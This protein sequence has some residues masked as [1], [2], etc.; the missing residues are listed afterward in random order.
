MN[1]LKTRK[2]Y[3]IIQKAEKQ[4]LYECIRNINN[5]LETLE[6]QKESQ[7]KKFKD[8]LNMLNMLNMP[9]QN[10]QDA[11]PDPDPDSDLERYRLFINKIKE[12]R[13]NKTK[14]RQINKFDCLFF[15]CHGYHHNH[16]RQTQ[17][18]E[19][20]NAQST[21][22]GHQNVP[23]SF[24]STSTQT[25]SNPVVPATSMAPHLPPVQT[26]HPA[27]QPGSH[28]PTAGIHI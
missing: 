2:S 8:S 15:K 12:Q 24:A 25:S 6:K 9:N 21:L 16:S 13:H 18:L 20:I 3:K 27:W 11:D 4:L 7:Y 22:S 17:N 28:L 14:R 23:S 5:T 19:N 10:V 26:Q 1:P